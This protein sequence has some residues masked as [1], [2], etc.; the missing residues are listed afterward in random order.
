MGKKALVLGGG[1]AKGS[2]EI[3]AWKAFEELNKS[4]D[5]IVGTSIG[6]LNGAAMVQGDFKSALRL[7]ENIDYK[8][9]FGDNDGDVSNIE[10][11]FD[12]IKYTF[13]EGVITDGGYDTNLLYNIIAA[14]LSEA[15]VRKSPVEFGLMTVEIPNMKPWGLMISEIPQGK[16]CDFLMAS[17]SCYPV[18]KPRTIDGK[19]FID[20]GYYD[21]LPVNLAIENGADDIVA[22]DLEAMGFVKEVKRSED[23]AVLKIKPYWNLG[24][25]FDFDKNRFERNRILGY[26]DTMKAYGYLEGHYYSFRNGECRRNYFLLKSVLATASKKIDEMLLRP[27][28]RLTQTLERRSCIGFLSAGSFL[29]DEAEMFC[30]IAETAALVYQLSPLEIYTFAKFNDALLREFLKYGGNI[31]LPRGLPTDI[32]Y[33]LSAISKAM[34][35]RRIT[36]L[37]VELMLRGK[38]NGEPIWTLAEILPREF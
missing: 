30:R 27:P 25:A 13:S 16:L 28:T 24:A 37:I 23:A 17:C 34:D 5:M 19:R 18:F 15:K 1:G 35:K 2:Y 6:S 22:V 38:S 31:S 32:T 12:M 29:R 3:G 36:S 9:V 10:N 21:N 4:W 14:S 11:T 8:N 7:W 20:G 26:N 33:I